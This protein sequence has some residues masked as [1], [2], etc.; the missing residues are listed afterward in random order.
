MAFSVFMLL[1]AE[2]IPAT[3]EMVPLIGIYLTITMSMAS[4][5]I[6]LTVFILQL[7]YANEFSYEVPRYAYNSMMKL[8]R[9]IGCMN[10]IKSFEECYKLNEE[11]LESAETPSNSNSRA[12]DVKSN[13]KEQSTDEFNF[14]LTSCFCHCCFNFSNRISSKSAIQQLPEPADCHRQSFRERDNQARVNRA[15]HLKKEKDVSFTLSDESNFLI[16][17][18]GQLNSIIKM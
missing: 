8:G 5:S 15:N 10:K 9:H 4:I 2:N 16:P 17:E 7:H 3:S 1:I 12:N 14:C 18:S 6:I 11:K 13:D